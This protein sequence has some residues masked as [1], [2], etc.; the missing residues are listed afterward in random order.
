MTAGIMA[1]PETVQAAIIAAVTEFDNW[2]E[3]VDPH[4]EHD[5]VAVE[6]E[7]HRVFAKCDYYDL[8]MQFLSPDPSD[9]KVTRRVLTLLLA[10]EY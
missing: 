8:Q 10:S 4:H 1:L 5:L 9:P 3:D 2:S 7:G 6:V